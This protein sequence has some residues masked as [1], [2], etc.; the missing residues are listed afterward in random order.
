MLIKVE[1]DINIKIALLY[2]IAWCYKIVSHQGMGQMYS[3][4][5]QKLL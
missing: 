4:E 2:N 5:K 1:N 3:F